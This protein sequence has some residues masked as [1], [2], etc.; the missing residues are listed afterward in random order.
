MDLL[1]VRYLDVLPLSLVFI[2]TAGLFLL[3]SEAGFRL[4][5]R[6]KER[7]AQKEWPQSGAITGA[8][9]GLLAFMLAFTFGLATSRLD[10]RKSLVVA[11]ANAVGTT[12]L[13][14]QMLPEPYPRTLKPL[15]LRYVQIRLEVGRR[16]GDMQRFA[17][18]LE[19]STEI[20]NRL[21]AQA[22]A[23]GREYPR[24]VILGLFVQSLNEMIDLQETRLDVA[25]Y[26]LP[27]GVLATLYFT[28]FTASA[29]VGINAGQSGSRAFVITLLLTVTLA[30]VTS[31]I[32]DLDRTNQALFQVKLQSMVD[33]R[34]SIE[35][36]DY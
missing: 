20:Q 5:R 21:W 35:G 8:T 1:P 7:S 14:S 33:L 16:P 24:S 31:L 13:R 18:L 36:S 9:L 29:M 10:S 2:L 19:E 23:L 30:V 11:E 32:I 26:R 6:L 4:G 15:F 25:R 28:A 17:R 34:E 27:P 3:F 12:W 22:R